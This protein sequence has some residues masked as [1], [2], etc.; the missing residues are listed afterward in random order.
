MK[1]RILVLGAGYAGLLAALRLARTTR[2]VGGAVTLVNASPVFADRIHL[3]ERSVRAAP[4]RRIDAVTRPG[5]VRFVEGWVTGIDLQHQR[6]AVTTETGQR[7]ESLAYDHLVYALGSMTDLDLIPGVRD[8][9]LTFTPDHSRRLRAVLPRWLHNTCACWSW[10]GGC[11]AS[12]RRPNWPKPT[13][14]WR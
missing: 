14:G 12:R 6:V 8:H 11:R 5:G 3:H 13:L 1:T 9:A 10:V 7:S 2:A 4:P